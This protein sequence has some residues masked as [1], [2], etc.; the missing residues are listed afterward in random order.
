MRLR[1][2]C[3]RYEKHWWRIHRSGVRDATWEPVGI[4]RPLALDSKQ[5]RD[6]LNKALG[7]RLDVIVVNH[8]A[9]VADRRRWFAIIQVPVPATPES[10][11]ELEFVARD[12]RSNERFGLTAGW[13]YVRHGDETI[14]VTSGRQFEIARI[15]LGKAVADA[16][17]FRS[18]DRLS[19]RLDVNP[20]ALSDLVAGSS[21]SVVEIDDEIAI[22]AEAP[23][24]R[25]LST[26]EATSNLISW[27]L[28]WGKPI[29]VIINLDAR[30]A[31]VNTISKVKEILSA[32]RGSSPVQIELRGARSTMVVR[33]GKE[34]WV[35]PRKG[36]YATLKAALGDQLS[37]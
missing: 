3:T 8:T 23:E 19:R 30:Q 9:K 6:K 2:G 5:I 1:Q 22:F 35:D 18:I 11:P 33:L 7:V 14:R 17:Y 13:T 31:S 15:K 27:P 16:N 24:R 12:F 34:F 28:Q 20:N 21:Q 37:T 29:P 25:V 26:S 36:L 32:H 4:D 10:T